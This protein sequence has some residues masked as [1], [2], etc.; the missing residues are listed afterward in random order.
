LEVEGLYKELKFIVN[1][2]V[3][4]NRVKSQVGRV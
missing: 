1:V 2:K 3:V 4:E